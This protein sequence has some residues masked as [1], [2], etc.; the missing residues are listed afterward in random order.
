M[1]PK[2]FIQFTGAVLSPR[3]PVGYRVEWMS[4]GWAGLC[5]NP[6]ELLAGPSDARRDAILAAADLAADVPR[7]RDFAMIAGEQWAFRFRTGWSAL[8]GFL[9]DRGPWGLVWRIRECGRV[10]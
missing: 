6:W 9:A 10:V 4:Q 8:A 7:A 5:A 2:D 3:V 1:D